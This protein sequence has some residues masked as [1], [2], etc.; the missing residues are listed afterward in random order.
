LD[1]VLALLPAND[2]IKSRLYEANVNFVYDSTTKGLMY[3]D[4]S[5]M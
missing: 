2:H 4:D 3:R 5:T 1:L